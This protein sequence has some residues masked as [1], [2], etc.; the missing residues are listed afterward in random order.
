MDRSI[1]SSNIK[2]LRDVGGRTADALSTSPDGSR[3]MTESADVAWKRETG[4][5][6][7]QPRAGEIAPGRCAEHG[8]LMWSNAM[9]ACILPFDVIRGGCRWQ[10]F[11]AAEHEMAQ[12]LKGEFV[13]RDG[14]RS[15]EYQLPDDEG[16]GGVW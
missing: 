13:M 3:S 9:R 16:S 8:G 4:P 1:T 2:S 14:T 5:V 15:P 12:R 7:D 11:E 6:A 10:S